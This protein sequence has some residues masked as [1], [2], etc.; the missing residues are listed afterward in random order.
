WRPA[1]A[2]RVCP[3]PVPTNARADDPR[4][5]SR[6]SG[7][8]RSVRRL[9]EALTQIAPWKVPAGALAVLADHLAMSEDVFV[10]DVKLLLQPVDQHDERL[11]LLLAG[12]ARREIPHQAD[13][14][15]FFVDVG[16]PTMSALNLPHPAR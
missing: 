3:H 1:R 6:E 8:A 5:P 10:G 12:R 11:Q 14:D 13:A 9:L 2:W 7:K 16:L 15:A 4:A